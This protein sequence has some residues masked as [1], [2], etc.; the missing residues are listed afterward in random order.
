MQLIE[1]GVSYKRLTSLKISSNAPSPMR[2]RSSFLPSSS[3]AL[4][5]ASTRC[6]LRSLR[7]GMPL[8]IVHVGEELKGKA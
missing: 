1:Y 8:G 6:L 3:P 4:S 5:A 7:N 2:S